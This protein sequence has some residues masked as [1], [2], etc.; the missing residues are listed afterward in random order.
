MKR[1]NSHRYPFQR[2]TRIA[3]LLQGGRYPNCTRLSA[4]WE[5]SRKTLQRDI[6]FL[7]DRLGAPIDYDHARRGYYL[8]EPTWRLPTL[9]LTEGELFQLAVVSRLAQQHEMT[10]LGPAL[11]SLLDK[12]RVGLP[13]PTRVDPLVVASQFSFHGHPTRPVAPPIWKALAR[14]VQ[15]GQA[16]RVSYRSYGRKEPRTHVIEPVHLACVDG[17]WMLVARIPPHVEVTILA[18]S[19]IA[20]AQA[21][22][23]RF[24]PPAFD[25]TTFFSN[26]FGR[27]V[28]TDGMS[29][30][31][32]VRFSSEAAEGIRERTWHPRQR[33]EEHR[34]G[35]V[36][37]CFP[38]PALYEVQRWVMQ[39]GS[40][41]E[42]LEP[43]ELRDAIAEDVGLMSRRLPG[44]RPVPPVKGGRR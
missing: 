10:P 3:A 27:F 44:K 17:D 32:V 23:T 25:P 33:L 20:S 9:D 39:W 1:M 42:V 26:R 2:L 40:E 29:H 21:T 31:V 5:V 4:E 8:T 41:A 37:L 6:D 22:T 12:I 18:V 36:T 24:T 14:G 11:E 28:G 43:R 7:R 13:Q 19:R 30:D 34:D 15:A 38:A 35:S 16:V